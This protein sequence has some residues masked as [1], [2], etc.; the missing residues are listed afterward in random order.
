MT[1]WDSEPRL[2]AAQAVDPGRVGQHGLESVLAVCGASRCTGDRC[3]SI[4]AAVALADDT[5]GDEGGKAVC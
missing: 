2:P 3:I 4:T 5:V 1:A